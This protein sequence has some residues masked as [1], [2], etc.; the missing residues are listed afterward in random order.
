MKKNTVRR[1]RRTEEE[2]ITIKMVEEVPGSLGTSASLA[3]RFGQT[4]FSCASL[5][6]MCFDVSFY[7]FT[8]FWYYYFPLF[9]SF[10]VFEL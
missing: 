2:G 10:F 6:F 8:A 1:R 5:F 7:G 3:L 9:N 4:M